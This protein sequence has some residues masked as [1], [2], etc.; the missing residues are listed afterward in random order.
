M[1]CG[2]LVLALSA[3]GSA[4]RHVTATQLTPRDAALRDPQTLAHRV[5]L[6]PGASPAP[7]LAKGTP[8]GSPYTVG[9]DRVYRVPLPFPDVY[10]FFRRQH[11]RG[12]VHASAS[13]VGRTWVYAHIHE[14]DWSFRPIDPFL[15]SRQLH[16]VIRGLGANVTAVRVQVDD[17]WTVRPATERVPDGTRVITIRRATSRYFPGLSRRITDRAKVARVVQLFNRL[18]L[19][20]SSPVVVACVAVIAGPNV[21]S[22]LSETGRVLARAAIV[23]GGRGG[24]CGAGIIVTVRGLRQPM[25]QGN[26]L[27]PVLALAGVPIST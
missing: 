5:A 22:F 9:I 11:P 21:V 3:C 23:N 10:R 24:P 4:A 15:S 1:A 19:Y 27:V 6:P 8:G 25:L 26:F 2:A 7:E 12:A 13:L 14:F 18:P 17:A 16:V 20:R